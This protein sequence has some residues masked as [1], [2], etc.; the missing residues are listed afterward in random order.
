[1]SEEIVEG[2]RRPLQEPGVAEALWAMAAGPDHRTAAGSRLGEI[3]QPCLV[4]VGRNDR[5]ATP[6]PLAHARTVVLDRCG[7]LPHEE[8]P[9]RTVQEI[10]SFIEGLPHQGSRA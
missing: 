5:W 10:L 4:I 1:M 6:V 8:Q 2:Y 3:D 9:S 7:H